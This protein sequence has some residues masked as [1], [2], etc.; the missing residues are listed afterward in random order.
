M[1][2]IYKKAEEFWREVSPHLLR[3][4]AKHGLALG[5]ANAFRKDKA[6]CLFQAALFDGKKCL[7]AALGVQFFSR[8]HLN[9]ALAKGEPAKKLYEAF[10]KAGLK[11]DGIVA[12]AAVADEFKQL[13]EQAGRPLKVNMKQGIYRCRKVIPPPVP[14]GVIFRQAESGD[15]KKLGAW[16]EDFMLEAVPND[17]PMDGVEFARKRIKAGQFFVIEKRGKLLSMAG[18][19]RDIGTSCSINGVYTPKP[20]RKQGYASLVTAKL[21]QHLLKEGRRETSLYTD[22]TN[23]TS[24]KI[25]QKIGYKFVCDS[26]HYGIV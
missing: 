18:K 25:Y 22:M 10:L 7:G 6:N 15:A 13:V 11:A 14:R 23:P 5:L 12:E 9:P 16:I 1:V 4:E 24:N 21:T 8:V 17:P 20:E 3:D 19:T 26:I 2:K